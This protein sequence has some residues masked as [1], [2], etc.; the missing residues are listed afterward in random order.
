M[1]VFGER[2]KQGN[3][4]LKKLREK[5]LGTEYRTNKLNPRMTAGQGKCNLLQA[6][7]FHSNEAIA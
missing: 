5:P 3:S 2:G 4:L 1:L 7:S 6:T